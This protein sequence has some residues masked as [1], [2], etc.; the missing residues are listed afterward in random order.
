MI[1]DLDHEASLEPGRVGSKSAMLAKARRAGL[2]VLPGFVIETSASLAHM[3]IG[4]RELRSR[5]SGGARL[6][7]VDE[8]LPD[9]E[10][11]VAAGRALAGSLVARSSTAHEESGE[12]AG[13]FTSYVDIAPE[14][15]PK[16]IVGCWASAFSVDALG[17]QQAAGVAP[18]SIAMAVLAQPALD[19]IAGGT[20]ELGIDGTIVVT[21][22][23]GPPA[24]LLQGWVKGM[25]AHKPPQRAWEG[26]ELVDLVGVNAL[27]ET[28]AALERA[29]TEMG[30]N[31]CEWACAEGLWI[32]QLGRVPP[33]R[34]SPPRRASRPPS[35]LI[36][37]VRAVVAAPG[38]L[39]ELLVLPWAIAGL[40]E[41]GPDHH[42]ADGDLVA[43]AME[44]SRSLTSDVWGLPPDA[45][46]AAAAACL[47]RLR[48]PEPESALEM[49]RGL[50]PP[51]EGMAGSLLDLVASLRARLVDAGVPD[52]VSAWHTSLTD[53]A[54]AVAGL[55]IEPRSR[56][57]LSRWEPLVADVVLAHGTIHRGQPASGGV[58]AGIGAHVTVPGEAVRLPPRSV[59]TAPNAIPNLS[60]L[61]WDAAGLVTDG[62]SPAAHVFESARSLGVPAVSGVDA[63][64][65]TAQIV[66]VDGDEGVVACLPL[67]EGR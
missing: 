59:V 23:S 8:P 36:P 21:G 22:V 24:P 66:A 25:V 54:N 12:W 14:H 29:N 9:P 41:T 67:H 1:T 16:A 47:E 20:A 31:R 2:P 37:V 50:R 62:G 13:A 46:S 30:A 35:D 32:L 11:V 18:G 7:M 5:G 39:G 61:M 60:Q 63:G 17:R 28:G 58:G 19:P 27:E 40:P 15:L 42:A 49:I 55:R 56:V 38:A 26:D 45:A 43:Q 6:A 53:A 33:I 51:E 65:D 4:A 44:L 57:G 34:P 3:G 64:Q 10:A 52:L 48:G